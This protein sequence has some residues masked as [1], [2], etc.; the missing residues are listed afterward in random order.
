MGH[1]CV[2]CGAALVPRVIEGR[3]VEACPND[4]FVLWRDPKVATAVVVEADGGVVLGRRAIEPGYGLWCLPGGFVNHD[5]DPEVAAARECIEEIGAPVELRG[6]LCVYHIAKTEASSMIGIAYRGRLAA[7]VSPSAGPE[8]LEVAVFSLDT[9]PPLAFPSHRQVLA[10]YL[11][12]QA[13]AAADAAPSGAEEAR[14]GGRPS[15]ARAA[16]T[17]RRK[18]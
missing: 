18:R 8:M 13:R 9:L 4:E 6:L 12:S 10:E 3:E 14:R 5:E 16:G 17:P 7:G 15:P 1:F 11:T 2:N